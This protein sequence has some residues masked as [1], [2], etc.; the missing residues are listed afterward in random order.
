M[1]HLNSVLY[2]NAL[3]PNGQMNIFEIAIDDFSLASVKSDS[4]ILSML[5]VVR[6][7]S[8][9]MPQLISF[10]HIYKDLSQW[11]E[12]CL[13]RREVLPDYIL[14]LSILFN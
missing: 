5:P 7:Y 10:Y 14:K 6:P 9:D 2:I 12:L 11:E 1:Y 3:Y 13:S 8:N 4:N